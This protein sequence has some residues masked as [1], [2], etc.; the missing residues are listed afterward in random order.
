MCGVLAG[1]LKVFQKAQLNAY[2][3]SVKPLLI[4]DVGNQGPTCI[5]MCSL[6]ATFRRRLQPASST[7]SHLKMAFRSKKRSSIVKWKQ[8]KG[9]E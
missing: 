2:I 1:S 5:A 6:S 9:S 8:K 7:L 3:M 4:H